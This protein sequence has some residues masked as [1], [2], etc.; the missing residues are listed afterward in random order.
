MIAIPRLYCFHKLL[1][2][3]VV[4]TKQRKNFK[5]DQ[6]TTKCKHFLTQPYTYP[7]EPTSTLTRTIPDAK[8]LKF[9]ILANQKI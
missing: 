5:T 1:A 6:Q 7:S 4:F 3:E 2:T 8:S 9:L